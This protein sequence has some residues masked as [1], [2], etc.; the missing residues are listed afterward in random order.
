MMTF[1]SFFLPR[2]NRERASSLS[3]V[4]EERPRARSPPFC[5]SWTTLR[6]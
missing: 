6:C 5:G 4:W 2:G 1:D 3:M